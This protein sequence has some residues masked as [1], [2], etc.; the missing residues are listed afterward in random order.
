MIQNPS[1]QTARIPL[2]VRTTSINLFNP[3]TFSGEVLNLHGIK[4][5][6]CIPQGAADTEG[7]L[8]AITTHQI[9]VELLHLKGLTLRN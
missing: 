4:I 9:P 3:L 1:T 6:S 2:E 5:G 7:L 8:H